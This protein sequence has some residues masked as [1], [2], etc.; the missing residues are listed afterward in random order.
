MA[1]AKE[2]SLPLESSSWVDWR[3][4]VRRARLDRPLSTGVSV[5]SFLASVSL[6]VYRVFGNCRYNRKGARVSRHETRLDLQERSF[7][8]RVFSF[9]RDPSRL[10]LRIISDRSFFNVNRLWR[11]IKSAFKKEKKKI[12][13]ETSKPQTFSRAFVV[14][15]DDSISCEPRASVRICLLFYAY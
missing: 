2:C 8:V 3:C 11:R 12:V 14:T 10:H 9:S 13:A 4:V 7:F 5:R 15:F 1:V 6:R